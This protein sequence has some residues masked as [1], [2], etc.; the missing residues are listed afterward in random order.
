[1]EAKET[2]PVE[3]VEPTEIKEVNIH[4]VHS[5]LNEKVNTFQAGNIKNNFPNWKQLTSDKDILKTVT[6]LHIEVNDVPISG[7]YQINFSE[8]EFIVIQNEIEKLL[9]KQIIKESQHECGELVS[10]I[11]LTEKSSGG[12]RLIL[13]LKKLNQNC[14]YHH[15]KMETI[16]SILRLVTKDCYFTSIDIKDA[17]YSVPIKADHQKWLKFIFDGKL[18]QFTCLPNGYCQGPLKFTKLLKPPLAHL[19][20]MDV[21]IASYIDDLINIESDFNKCL[22]NG[23]KCVNLLLS[24]GFTINEV[25]SIFYPPQII[26]FLGMIINSIL[27]TVTLTKRKKDSIKKLSQDIIK[28]KCPKIRKVARLLGKYSN[29]FPASKY[30]RLH[31]RSLQNDKDHCLKQNRGNFNAKMLLSKE[32]K[33]DIAW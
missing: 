17:Y 15:F 24:L 12:F 2:G 8:T 25:K 20:L 4:N 22:A 13:N 23:L 29:S 11:F 28:M 18:Y 6:G 32:A 3:P 7:G 30:G 16:N 10:P 26:E 19:R 5:V 33:K 1:M 14:D 9:Q 27:M 21:I 31:F